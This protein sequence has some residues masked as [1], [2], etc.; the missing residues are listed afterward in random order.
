MSMACLLGPAAWLTWNESQDRALDAPV[1]QHD[2]LRF[3]MWLA[4]RDKARITS[5]LLAHP[6]FVQTLENTG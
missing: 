6:G 3:L 4:P 5:R 1:P 2:E